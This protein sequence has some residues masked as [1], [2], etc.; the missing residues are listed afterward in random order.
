MKT[1]PSTAANCAT[2]LTS[3][4]RS[5]R[6]ISESC[7]VAGTTARRRAAQ[8]S[9]VAVH[10][11]QAQLHHGL[12][13]FLDKQRNAVGARDDLGTHL[14]RHRPAGHIVP[15]KLLRLL[16]VE[17]GDRQVHQR[18]LVLQF[19][20]VCGRAKRHDQ[21][22]A[23]CF[24]RRDHARE[25]FRRRRIDPMRILDEEKNWLLQRDVP[26]PADEQLQGLFLQ[27]LRRQ[28]QRR[29]AVA[30]RNR[31]QGRHDRHRLFQDRSVLEQ[32]GFELG[33]FLGGVSSCTMP[34][35]RS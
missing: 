20:I 13:Q 10:V 14:W 9:I 35:R 34:A 22:H 21:E 30:E 15:Q 1:R 33:E 17:P 11:R 28:L 24:Q 31:Q 5:R 16:T 2:G 7:R 29:I 8:R 25:Q 23:G 32:Q 18:R 19:E 4:M 3:D 12:A 27:L 6:A 26:D